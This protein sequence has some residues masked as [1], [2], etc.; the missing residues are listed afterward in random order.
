MLRSAREQTGINL[1]VELRYP[2]R[3]SR[4]VL[5]D[6]EHTRFV[7]RFSLEFRAFGPEFGMFIPLEVGV[8]IF[9]HPFR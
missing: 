6:G 2:F 1:P 7:G 5:A 4:Y 8:Q 9:E 3:V